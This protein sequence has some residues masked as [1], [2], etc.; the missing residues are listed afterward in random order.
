[1]PNN[2][3]EQTNSP[4][5]D[6]NSFDQAIA[7]TPE[8]L[9]ENL[10][11]LFRESLHHTQQT[12]KQ[13]FENNA[14][15][16]KLVHLRAETVDQILKRAWK[17]FIGSAN[18]SIALIAVGGYGR[19]ELH[20]ASDIDLLILLDGNQHDTYA[21]PIQLFLTFLWD[22][23]L[24]VGQSVR[25]VKE[26]VTEAKRDITVATSLMEAR[27]LEGPQPLYQYFREKV[28]PKKIW[29]SQKFF[30]AKLAEQVERHHRYHD[31]AYNL[32]PNIKENPGGLRD[33]QV[34]G[35]V[36]KRHFGTKTLQ[37]LVSHNFLT[38][39][40]YRT[41]IDSQN[42]LWRIRI[43][44]HLATGRREDRL[45]FD[46]QRDLA[47]LFGYTD[48]ARH[49][50]VEKFMKTY[51]R[52]VLELN[53]LNEM[54]LQLFEEATLNEG[55]RFKITPINKRFQARNG[56]VEVTNN[57][58]FKRY[59][60]ALLEIFLILQ[61]HPEL[62]GVRAKTIRLIRNH[63]Y[64]IDEKFRN[65]VRCQSLFME[66]FKQP[67]GLTHQLRR[68]N[69]YGILAAYL[70]VFGNIVGQMQH[71]L[72]HTYTVDE[73]T[74]FLV[75]NLRRFTVA[76]FTDEFPLCSK[77]IKN[78]PK[79]EL[80]YL[81][82]FFHDIGKGRGGDHSTLGSADAE[83]F[84][85]SHGLSQYDTNLVTWLV[86]N[87]L[88]MSTT[89]Q[90]KDISD[91]DV[92]NDFAEMIGSQER[93]DYL[94]LLTVADIRATSPTLWNSWKDSLLADLYYTTSRAFRRGLQNPLDQSERIAETKS[95]AL[96]QLLGQH[97]TEARIIAFWDTLD[98][99]YFLR[100]SDDE[101]I[102]HIQSIFSCSAEDYPLVLIRE[103][104]H[105]GGTELFICTQDEGYIF[106]LTTAVIA[107]L[108]LNITDARI[109]TSE[110]GITM[111]TFML[112]EKNGEPILDPHRIADVKTKLTRTLANPSYE[113]V[114]ASQPNKP[115]SRQL[116]H[117]PL[118]T[119]ITFRTDTRNLVTIMEVIAR[120]QPGLLARIARAMVECDINIH[121][122]KIA[123][124]GAKAEDIFYITNK[125]KNPIESVDLLNK[126]RKTII[127]FLG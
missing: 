22:I 71:D 14:P 72:F 63:R 119:D 98:D 32:E 65:D 101:I 118:A 75:R 56:F 44:L 40:E 28:G 96:K 94:Y 58:I 9:P 114:I 111:D 102:W 2:T 92:V 99:D 115:L 124:F 81:A 66:I 21:E 106:A 1:M 38:Q 84:G 18:T 79:Q 74:M 103:Q 42:F 85:Q 69:R 48:D 11:A 19:G 77:I 64:R 13:Q 12:L 122:A 100:H 3:T 5:Y 10:V 90:R 26:C 89:A 67:R 39:E 125:Q 57:N 93:L 33:I 121:K 108:G 97:F 16:D 104:T 41:L 46:L 61:Q 47:K 105:R 113:N 126:L 116:K 50:A 36:A 123:T 112:L 31:T 59:P 43:G 83:K 95:I 15:A 87:H 49:L 37:G 4:Q 107:R 20:P 25:S 52:T 68:M 60:F 62:R 35:W 82:G 29:S 91:P 109:I 34:I 17:H 110:N 127:E 8:N 53:R 6:W 45:M 117:F 23:G 76:K 120:D 30:S 51:Y 24:E 27:L 55:K 86:Q 78:I 80:L 54:L 88:M 7:N 70:P 73:H